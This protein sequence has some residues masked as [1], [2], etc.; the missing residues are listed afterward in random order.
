MKAIRRALE[1]LGIEFWVDS[2]RLAAGDLLT[3]AV[4]QAIDACEHFLVILSENAIDAHWV[5]KEIKRAIAQ[6][7]KVIPVL[8]P[9]IEPAALLRWFDEEPVGLKL[10]LGPDGVAA[11]LPALLA[12]L[13]FRRTPVAEL[14]LR[15]TDPGIETSGARR[16]ATATASLTYSP[17]D[18]GPQVEGDRYILTRHSARSKPTTSPGI[19][20][21]M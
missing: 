5:A 13:G 1:A 12:A 16:R 19:W 8:L 3:P 7:K 11:G 18:G 4:M 20:N 2:Q 15:L 10:S 9:P 14:I 6:K 21:A 17:P